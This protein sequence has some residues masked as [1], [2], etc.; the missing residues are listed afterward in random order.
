M[1][2]SSVAAG[3]Y[4]AADSDRGSSGWGFDRRGHEFQRHRYVQRS[5]ERG[6]RLSGTIQ[7]PRFEQQSRRGHGQLQRREQHGH[8]DADQHRLANSMTYM[9]SVV[10]GAGGVMD[11]AGNALAA[12]VFSSFTTIAAGSTAT[13][14]WSES[15]TPATIDSGDGGPSIELGVKFTAN[16]SGLV[17]GIQ[18]YK[19]ASNTGVHTGSLWSS[20]GQLLATGTFTNETATGWQTLV[21]TTPVALT[22]GATDVASYHTTTGHYSVNQVILHLVVLQRSADRTGQRRRLPVRQRW[23]PHAELPG[24]QLLGRTHLRAAG[25]LAVPA[26]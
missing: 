15:I 24:Q 22:V 6:Q 12:N 20:T 18:F 3:G 4:H 10:G 1:L 5:L 16:A 19:A 13:S 23:I 25:K 2:F 11:L 7:L 21:F 14:L 8:A 17:T 26:P 9:L